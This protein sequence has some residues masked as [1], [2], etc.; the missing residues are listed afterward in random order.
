M[1]LLSTLLH[2]RDFYAGGLMVL[3]GCGVIVQA[4]SYHVGTLMH[5]GP[6]FSPLILGVILTL[7]GMLILGGAVAAGPEHERILPE[8]PEWWGWICILAS[9]ALFIYFGTHGGMAPATLMG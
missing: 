9:P 5:M 2:K 4:R 6:G 8:H 1:T 7:L 3:M